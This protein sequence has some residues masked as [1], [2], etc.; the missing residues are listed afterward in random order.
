MEEEGLPGSIG[1]VGVGTIGSA[2]IRGLLS[3]GPGAPAKLP[4]VVLSP[5]GALKAEALAEAFPGNV[6]IAKSNQEV[7]DEVEC[8][9]VAVLFKQVNEVFGALKFRKEQKVMTLTAGLM[10]TRL[11]ELCAP[12]TTCVSAIPLPPVAKRSGATLLTPRLPWAEAMLKVCGSCVVV[13]TEAEFKRLLVVTCMMGD[14][15][16]RQL[17]AQ[18]WLCSH[19]IS[20]ADAASW[21][22]STFATFAADSSGAQV[23]T[24]QKLVEEQTPG[25]LNEMV[26]RAQEEDGSYKSLCYSL[27]AVHHRLVSGAADPALAPAA[28]RAKLA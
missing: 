7:V 6:V 24:F 13:E 3:P 19:G 10:P 22:S 14:F 1:V 26:W 23:D 8:V 28:K 16:K 15:Y 27:D 5:R 18:Q 9:I 4:R 25:G 17:T 12:A 21:V 2:L 20:E 11:K